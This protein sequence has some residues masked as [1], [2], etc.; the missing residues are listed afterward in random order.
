MKALAPLD[1]SESREMMRGNRND[2]YSDSYAVSRIGITGAGSTRLT[3][4]KGQ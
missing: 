4:I 3:W 1:R 2:S